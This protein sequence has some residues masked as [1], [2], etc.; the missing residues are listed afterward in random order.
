[1][2]VVVDESVVPLT[3]TDVVALPSQCRVQYHADLRISQ[4]LITGVEA[5]LL[6]V[7]YSERRKIFGENKYSQ[8]PRIIGR[9]NWQ[10]YRVEMEDGLG[11]VEEA[12]LVRMESLGDGAVFMS[13][14]S[15]ICLQLAW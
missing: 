10:V 14:K 3:F 8:R 1:M 5:L 4:Y 11:G 15:S 13:N 12:E 6:C 7:Q 2:I 9:S